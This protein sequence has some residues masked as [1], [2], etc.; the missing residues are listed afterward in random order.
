MK[1]VYKDHPWDQESMSLYVG[2]LYIQVVSFTVSYSF[3]YN[4]PR[5]RISNQFYFLN[6]SRFLMQINATRFLF[7]SCLV[8]LYVSMCVCVCVYMC[9]CMLVCV[10]CVYMCV[11]V[12]FDF[13]PSSSHGWRRASAI[14]SLLS[15]SAVRNL[16]NMSLPSEI[17]QG[18]DWTIKEWLWVLLL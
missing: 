18:N 16:F 9:V 3:S 10:V 1:P 13:I 4:P 6:W 2:G 17:I 11:C 12:L 8:N 5:P 7:I 14:V 15:G